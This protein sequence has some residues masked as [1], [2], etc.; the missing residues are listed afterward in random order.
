MFPNRYFPVSYYPPGYWPKAGTAQ[1]RHASGN[2]ALAR[3]HVLESLRRQEELRA[4]PR[5]LHQSYLRRISNGPAVMGFQL[6]E[7]ERE[8]MARVAATQAVLLSEL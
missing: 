3:R 4:R 6:V 7:S 1:R 8:R 2:V 5:S